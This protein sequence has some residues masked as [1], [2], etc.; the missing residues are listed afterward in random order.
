MGVRATHPRAVQ[1]LHIHFSSLKLVPWYL[2]GI[3]S[4]TCLHTGTRQCPGP[5]SRHAL[6]PPHLVPSCTWK[7]TQVFSEETSVSEPVA[8]VHWATCSARPLLALDR[9]HATVLCTQSPLD[10]TKT[11]FANSV[12]VCGL[13]TYHVNLVFQCNQGLYMVGGTHELHTHEDRHA[14]VIKQGAKQLT[15]FVV[16]S[17]PLR[18]LLFFSFL[19]TTHSFKENLLDECEKIFT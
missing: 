17:R 15:S 8:P 9:I 5:G 7:T 10:L 12:L 2:W 14:V 18:P 16:Y 19:K 3:G 11:T 13:K 1:Y 4:R 6:S